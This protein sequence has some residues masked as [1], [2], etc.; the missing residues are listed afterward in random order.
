[1]SKSVLIIWYYLFKHMFTKFFKEV[2]MENFE[3]V[4]S[5]A[6]TAFSL[7]VTSVIFV[8]RMVKALKERNSM[9]SLSCLY[10]AI[11]PLMEIAEGFTGY[12]G[13]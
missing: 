6:G 10:D 7:L 1:M 3:V 4:L 12:S 9:Q 2:I 13:E 11:A 5:L 8:I